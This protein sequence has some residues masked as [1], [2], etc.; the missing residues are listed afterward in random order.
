MSAPLDPKGDLSGPSLDAWLDYRRYHREQ[1]HSPRTIESAGEALAQL[2]RYL[3]E[4]HPG[5]TV[6]TAARHQVSDYLIWCGQT[7]SASTQRNRHAA[8]RAFYR[9]AAHPEQG[10][11]ASSPAEGIAAPAAAYKVPGVLTDA[12]LVALLGACRARRDATAAEK[13]A[14]ARDEAIIRI[15]C[16]PGSPR[17]SEMAALTVADVDLDQD[18]VSIERGKG[19][20]S[21]VIGL[22]PATARAVS[23]YKRLR[24]AH[25]RAA[26]T[27]LLWLGTKG[28]LT[29][30]GLGQML[31]RRAQQAGIGHAHP[32]QLRHTAFADFDNATGGHVNA[33][34]ALFGWKSGAMAQH[35]GKDVRNRR[36][37]ALARELA[38]GNRLRVG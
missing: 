8:L 5:A 36:A 21:R 10:I 1:Q 12:Q 4:H 25:P 14:A 19:G 28:P 16:E 15:W 31:A 34:M 33:E 35:Y 18:A 11:I 27:G 6:L 37:V 38:R 29:R 23:K 24:A 20:A 9:F 13:L 26:E 32:H 7:R 2:Q 3:D 17:C 22:S 30:F